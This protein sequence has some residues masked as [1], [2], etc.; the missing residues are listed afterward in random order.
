MVQQCSLLL[1]LLAIAL[2]CLCMHQCQMNKEGDSSQYQADDTD[3]VGC[4]FYLC[5][6]FV[7][8]VILSFR[9]VPAVMSASRCVLKPSHRVIRS[10]IVT[11][12]RSKC[13]SPSGHYVGFTNA[14]LLSIFEQHNIIFY[15][16]YTFYILPALCTS[17]VKP[18]IGH[19][20]LQKGSIVNTFYTPLL[21]QLCSDTL[22]ETIR[23][24]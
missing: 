14:E 9:K 4:V 18:P 24:F 15:T 23:F 1:L 8:V 16:I 19:S 22:P 2:T 5:I 20:Q 17:N 12:I 6:P 11:L 3:A 10:C 21:P 13:P 7:Y